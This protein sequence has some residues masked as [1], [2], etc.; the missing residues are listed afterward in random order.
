MV[1]Y[2]R[3]ITFLIIL[4]IFMSILTPLFTQ[5][6]PIALYYKDLIFYT[7]QN[8]LIISTAIISILALK[9]IQILYI[10]IA[11]GFFLQDLILLPMRFFTKAKKEEKNL[12]MRIKIMRKESKFKEALQLTVNNYQNSNKILFQHLFILLKLKRTRAFLK[13]FKHYQCG[14]VIPLF[15][16]LI[17]GRAQW[18]KNLLISRL[19]KANPS[20]DVITYIYVKNLLDRKIYK[21]SYN[22]TQD[23]I[24]NKFIFFR[25]QYTFYLFN[26]L[27][28][29]LENIEPDGNT[30]FAVEYIENIKNYHASIQKK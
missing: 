27:A 9:I 24:N 5:N 4:L 13:T 29:K 12:L 17:D 3:N 25:E 14:K 7:T 11:K 23:F 16:A 6:F 10:I 18:R 15:F 28:L 26:K 22:L 19:Y 8:A 20:N 30:D 2:I 21:K 1:A